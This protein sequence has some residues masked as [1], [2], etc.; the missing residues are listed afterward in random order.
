MLRTTDGFAGRCGIKTLNGFLPWSYVQTAKPDAMMHISQGLRNQGIGYPYGYYGASAIAKPLKQ[1]GYAG[2][3]ARADF[4]L[5]GDISAYGNADAT[6]E[7][8]F[9]FT[10]NGNV[11][12]NG[13]A[14]FAAE[15]NFTAVLRAQ[16]NASAVFDIGARPSAFDVAQAVWFGT[17][18]DGLGANK[19]MEVLLAVAAGKT[20]IDT[21][22]PN[23]IVTFRNVPDTLNRV[24]ATMDG[25]ER[26]SVTIV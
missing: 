13:Y 15:G 4:R 16:G 18:F 21:S 6:S 5:N 11:L 12:S 23:P 25:S 9:D 24:Q 8:E 2:A 10:A 14:T 7:A 3:W 20:N 22:G 17:T 1:L 19:I 26:Q